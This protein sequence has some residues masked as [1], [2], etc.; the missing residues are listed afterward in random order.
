MKKTS[1]VLFRELCIVIGIVASAFIAPRALSL[2]KFALISLGVFLFINTVLFI[3][4]KSAKSKSQYRLVA[5]DYLAILLI[6]IYW[7][8]CYFVR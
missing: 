3:R 1:K 2:R 6:G 4:T 7:A 5:R 8:I